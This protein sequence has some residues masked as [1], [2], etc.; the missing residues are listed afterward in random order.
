MKTW[1]S[2]LWTWLCYRWWSFVLC[3]YWLCGHP[4]WSEKHWE[5]KGMRRALGGRWGRW[6]FRWLG[7]DE[8][9]F[10]MWWPS[11]C[12]HYPPPPTATSTEPLET[13]E[14]IASPN[15]QT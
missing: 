6:E 8:D 3:L 9:C 14:W 15:T 13:E 4:E 7:K 5:R 12:E 10:K 1:L 11:P 2:N